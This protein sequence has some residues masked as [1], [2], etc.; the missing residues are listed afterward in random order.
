ME[1]EHGEQLWSDP[2]CQGKGRATLSSRRGLLHLPNANQTKV[3][4]NWIN[5]PFVRVNNCITL[6]NRHMSLLFMQLS[7]GQKCC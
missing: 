7:P 5:V 3:G 1:L 4:V 2:G 6:M